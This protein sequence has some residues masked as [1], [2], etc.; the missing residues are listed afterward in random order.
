MSRLPRPAIPRPTACPPGAIVAIADLVAVDHTTSYLALHTAERFPLEVVFGDF[1]RGRYVWL[2]ENVRR[3]E[4]PVP[5]KGALGL[6]T[7]P[8]E[9]AEVVDH[10]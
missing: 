7:V 5:C 2:L 9:I 10:G 3:L 6:W 8:E 1:T 4:E